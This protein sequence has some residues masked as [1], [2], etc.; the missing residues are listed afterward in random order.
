MLAILTTDC[1]SIQYVNVSTEG[2]NPD[3]LT[4]KK[5]TRLEGGE[6]VR[7]GGKR[8]RE[9]ERERERERDGQREREREKGEKERMV[10]VKHT[11]VTLTTPYQSNAPPTSRLGN[12]DV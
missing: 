5:K 8:E 10:S 7:E 11:Q 6:R 2:A 4:N 12:L 3:M 1:L 9:K